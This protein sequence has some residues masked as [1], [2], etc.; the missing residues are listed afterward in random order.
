MQAVQCARLVQNLGHHLVVIPVAEI[1]LIQHAAIRLLHIVVQR[2]QVAGHRL[3]G[4]AL[5]ILGGGFTGGPL[6]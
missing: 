4:D 6:L 2:I 5:A 1:R 3:E